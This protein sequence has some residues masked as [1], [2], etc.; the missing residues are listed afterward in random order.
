LKRKA[1]DY[2]ARGQYRRGY[3]AFRAHLQLSD[4]KPSLGRFE[5][6]TDAEIARFLLERMSSWQEGSVSLPEFCPELNPEPG[7][8]LQDTK[9]L[10]VVSKYINNSATHI[11]NE[12]VDHLVATATRASI[13]ADV[14][15]CDDCSYP[16]LLGIRPNAK[17][18]LAEL[19]ERVR[20]T[21]PDVIFLDINFVGNEHS[22]NSSLIRDLKDEAN[23][24]VIGFIGDAWMP[25]TVS[26]AAYWYPV[27]DAIYHHTPH[28][29][30]Y[31]KY[32][33]KL[34]LSGYP[35]N[36]GRFHPQDER[37]ISVSFLGSAPPARAYLL[38]AV[39][40]LGIPN[41]RLLGH[42]RQSTCPDITEYA[43]IMRRSKIVLDFSGLKHPRVNGRV[44]QSLNCGSLL[45]AE[46]SGGKIDG[47]FVPYVHYV[48]FA[49][50]RELRRLVRFFIRH[51]SFRKSIGEAAARWTTERYSETALWSDILGKARK[52][53]RV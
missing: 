26:L 36:R 42:E 8:R 17:V 16:D 19:E 50:A 53:S 43:S 9:M 41:S 33:N 32:G 31:E 46:Q 35:T 18:S 21:R 44:F 37:D 1:A 34:V 11:E 45:L 5:A 40:A 12:M 24:I 49:N 30:L 48:P 4:E 15:Y 52:L 22:I 7:R 29:P 25:N 23:A 2:F 51:D 20:A 14:F 13:Q 10:V 47:F 6:A 27:C 28:S 38:S 3:Y 39:K